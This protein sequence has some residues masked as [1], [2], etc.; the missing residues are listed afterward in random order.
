MPVYVRGRR[1]KFD[2]GST[3]SSSTIKVGE[4]F[5]LR[6]KSRNLEE[7]SQEEEEKEVPF[8]LTRQELAR[9][10]SSSSSLRVVVVEK[11]AKK[12]K[13]GSRS[14]RL[15]CIIGVCVFPSNPAHDL[16]RC[17][18]FF[19]CDPSIDDVRERRVCVRDNCQPSE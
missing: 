13:V 18:F 12:E 10:R 5:W 9:R 6:K 15:L 16:T 17:Q 2:E 19:R 14:T 1:K 7:S 8:F 3:S 11:K 4:I